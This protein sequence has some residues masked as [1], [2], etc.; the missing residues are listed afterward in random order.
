MAKFTR[1]RESKTS[2]AAWLLGRALSPMKFRGKGLLALRLGKLLST[3]C[4]ES[5]CSPA[6]GFRMRVRLTDRIEKLMWVRH[7]EPE[8]LDLLRRSLD[9]G[10]TYVDVGAH[11]G[12]FSVFAASRVGPSGKVFAFEADPACFRRLA[13]NADAYPWITPLHLAVTN[14]PGSLRFFGSPR[15]EESG[16]GTLFDTGEARP[17]YIVQ[18]T[19]LDEWAYSEQV[20]RIDLIKIDVEGAEYLVLEG[21]KRVLSELRPTV[22]FEV[23][24]VC[25][26]RGGKTTADVIALIAECGYHVE[27]LRNPQSSE[28]VS[29]LAVPAE[30]AHTLKAAA[31]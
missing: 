25:T 3:I 5:M 23:N 26:A 27:L 10:M 13:A 4:P 21:A 28:P 16:W 31:Q 17:Q 19:T 22:V 9:K 20:H 29:V 30:R 11:I 15:V 8:L 14:A 24:E 18:A 1:S 12:Y 6:P 7:Y 2:M